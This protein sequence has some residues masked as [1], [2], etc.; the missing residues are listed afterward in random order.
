[1]LLGFYKQIFK[2]DFIHQTTKKHV[3]LLGIAFFILENWYSLL[4]TYIMS[5]IKGEWCWE[6][7]GRG[8][9]EGPAVD[10]TE[11]G[12]TQGEHEAQICL[13]WHV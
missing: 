9:G 5:P 1:M 10:T 12:V 6:E 13:T 7:S 8:W 11:S 2:S 4:F 3:Y